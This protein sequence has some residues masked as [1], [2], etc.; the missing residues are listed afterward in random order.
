MA[1]TETGHGN[2]VIV[3]VTKLSKRTIF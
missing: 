2:G 1:K 3:C